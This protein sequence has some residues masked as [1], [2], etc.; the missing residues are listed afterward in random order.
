MLAFL[1]CFSYQTTDVPI[2]IALEALSAA[3]K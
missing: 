3:A 1:D 2:E